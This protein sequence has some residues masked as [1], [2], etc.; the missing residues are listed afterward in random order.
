M[1]TVV[2]HR[3][4]APF[5]SLELITPADMRDVGNKARQL[6]IARTQRGIG[7]D[8]APFQD[9]ST[10]YAKLRSEAG[11]PTGRV[12]LTVSG[13]MLN[14]LT[15]VTATSRTVSIGWVR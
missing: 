10:G 9:Y 11:L 1:A 7:S 14:G 4:F 8:G 12:T 6:I 3:T 13:E 15:I 2:V 5:S